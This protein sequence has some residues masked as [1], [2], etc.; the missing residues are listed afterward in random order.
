M[1]N[2]DDFERDIAE[3]VN[4]HGL[5]NKIGI[6]DYI[7]AKYVTTTIAALNTANVEIKSERHQYSSEAGVLKR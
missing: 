2:L 5:D 7:L 1:S 4:R 6:P 3:V